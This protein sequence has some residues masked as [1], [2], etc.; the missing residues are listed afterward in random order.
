MA[1]DV[2]RE[3]ILPWHK[4]IAEIAHAH[5]K[6]FLFHCCGDMYPLIDDY[7]NEVKIDAK[8]SFEEAVLPVTEAK[9]RYGDRL[10]LLGGMDVDFLARSTP[11][12]VTAKTFEI[13]ETCHAGGGYFLGSGNWVTNYIPPENYLAM[14]RAGRDFTCSSAPN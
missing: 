7:L 1:P 2:L 4:R 9:R 13:L 14:L 5:N 11:E 10:T 12:A 8:H 3:L 6:L